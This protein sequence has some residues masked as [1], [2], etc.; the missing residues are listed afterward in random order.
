MHEGTVL[1]SVRWLPAWPASPCLQLMQLHGLSMRVLNVSNNCEDCAPNLAP[2]LGFPIG[3]LS[4]LSA[5]PYCTFVLRLPYAAERKIVL[6]ESIP[7][8]GLHWCMKLRNAWA[9]PAQL[10]KPL[11][12]GHCQAPSHP[13][14][15]SQGV[16]PASNFYCRLNGVNTDTVGKMVARR[17]AVALLVLL[18]GAYS[19]SA[20]PMIWTAM[21]KDCKAV[22]MAGYGPHSAPV[23]DE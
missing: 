4:L 12:A 23:K 13:R 2:L 20:Y 8:N 1:K 15:T 14:E 5:L 6:R 11:R 18:L 7:R 10:G 22:P 19:A 17:Q 9:E 21:T 16:K 3:Y